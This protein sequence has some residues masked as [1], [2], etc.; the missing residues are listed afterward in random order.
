MLVA[1]YALGATGGHCDQTG[2][3]P[4]HVFGPE[5][6]LEKGIV[7]GADEG[8]QAVR[9]DIKYG[10]DVIKMCASGGVLSLADDVAAP[11]LTDEELTAIIDEAHRLDR[12]TA[13]HC[14]RRPRGAVRRSRPASTRSSTGPS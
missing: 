13:A 4:E 11:Q 10:A 3:P 14:P 7:H 5:P 6:G 12:K 9:L 1:R 8:R 2:F